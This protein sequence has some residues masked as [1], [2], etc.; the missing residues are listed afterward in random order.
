MPGNCPVGGSNTGIGRCFGSVDP[1]QP[2]DSVIRVFSHYSAFPPTG[3]SPAGPPWGRRQSYRH[4]KED[5][6]DVRQHCGGA[7]LL[8]RR[9]ERPSSAALSLCLPVSLSTLA[10]GTGGYPFRAITILTVLRW[11]SLFFGWRA[12]AAGLLPWAFL[13]FC[14]QP[15]FQKY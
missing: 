11:V 5:S 15:G 6:D 3:G 2:P 9:R 4:R 1:I 13:S 8:E 7:A 10:E 14:F 12:K